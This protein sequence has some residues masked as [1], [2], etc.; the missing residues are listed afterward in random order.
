[1][2]SCALPVA[3]Q[4]VPPAMR[5]EVEALRD[6]ARGLDGCYTEVGRELYI[7]PSSCEPRM[8]RLHRAPEPV[9]THA[10]GLALVDRLRDRPLDHHTNVAMRAWTDVLR[11]G[12]EDAVRYLAQALSLVVP[13]SWVNNQAIRVVTD[14]ML[15]LTRQPIEPSHLGPPQQPAWDH[16]PTVHTRWSTRT[17][18]AWLAW[19][20]ARSHEDL[21]R[22]QAEGMRAHRRNLASEDPRLRVLAALELWRHG[23]P[24]REDLVREQLR[25]PFVHG[26]PR[27]V[28]HGFAIR[29]RVLTWQQALRA[30]RE[31]MAARRAGT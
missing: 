25:S 8:A 13:G 22:W 24:D 27:R 17:R 10:A 14:A 23:A 28:L 26:Q 20:G 19:Y 29:H 21:A 30:T 15:D 5:D 16:Y 31:A 12:G 3:A 1:V 7:Q 11:R 2:W 18:D 9:R 6:D 4:T